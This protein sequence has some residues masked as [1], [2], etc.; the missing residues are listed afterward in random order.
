MTISQSYNS[1]KDLIALSEQK[2]L[3]QDEPKVELVKSSCLKESVSMNDMN[4]ELKNF[5]KQKG[6]RG[7]MLR[8]LLAHFIRSCFRGYAIFV[9]WRGRRFMSMTL[10]QLFLDPQAFNMGLSLGFL[11]V[12]HKLVQHFLRT[13]FGGES[14]VSHSIAGF[15]GG[16]TLFFTRMPNSIV[17]TISLAILIRGIHEI[18]ELKTWQSENEWGNTD[19]YIFAVACGFIV[20]FFMYYPKILPK[21]YVKSL[22]TLSTFNVSKARGYYINTYKFGETVQESCSACFH[23]HTEN[24]NYDR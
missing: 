23:P 9:L 7:R 15:L 22:E 10:R 2:D 13:G 6:S 21:S 12:V 5:S 19:G 18:S 4:F 24:C 3:I 1:V 20:H 8:L 14:F 11:V 16:C 17:K